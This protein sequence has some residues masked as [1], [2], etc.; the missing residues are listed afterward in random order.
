MPCYIQHYHLGR[1]LRSSAEHRR[2]NTCDSQCLGSIR[3]SVRSDLLVTIFHAGVGK[4]VLAACFRTLFGCQV[5]ETKLLLTKSASCSR[6][7]PATDIKPSCQLVNADSAGSAA[8]FVCVAI[9]SHI[10]T[11]VSLYG[12]ILVQATTTMAFTYPIVRRSLSVDWC[13]NLPPYSKP[14]RV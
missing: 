11:T 6:V 14:A 5:A 4:A 2:N 8:D 7:I 1:D 10:T 9:A 13:L 3:T 12:C